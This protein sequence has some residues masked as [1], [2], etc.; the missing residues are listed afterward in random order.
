MS[1]DAMKAFD[2]GQNSGS[3]FRLDLDVM[4][5]NKINAES[6]VRL[7]ITAWHSKLSNEEL[8]IAQVH[9]ILWYGQQ[10]SLPTG[11]PPNGIPSSKTH[12]L[13]LAKSGKLG[14]EYTTY[15]QLTDIDNTTELLLLSN[16]SGRVIGSADEDYY[17]KA[18][19]IRKAM[20][21]FRHY[22]TVALG[23]KLSGPFDHGFLENYTQLINW[24]YKKCNVTKTV[25][26]MADYFE[27]L[28]KA[29]N[30]ESDTDCCS[31]KYR[32]VLS[33]LFQTGTTTAPIKFPD[34]D[35]DNTQL[36]DKEKY[37]PS[38]SILFLYCK[39]RQMDKKTWNS[40]EDEFR[41]EI[42]GTNYN[43]KSWMENKPRLFELID[44][45]AKSNS[46]RGGVN[47]AQ[48]L[49]DED[50]E[51]DRVELEIEPG[52]VMY[53]SPK[54]KKGRGQN[55]KSK[56][57]KYAAAARR[58]QKSNNNASNNRQNSNWNNQSTPAT[59]WNCKICP[60]QNGKFV[61][62]KRGQ[63]CPTNGFIPAR[64]VAV[65]QSNETEQIDQETEIEKEDVKTVQAQVASMR[66][67][68]FPYDS[69]STDESE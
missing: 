22:A 21:H 25:E 52:L 56:V 11:Y 58:G 36:I 57:Q 20:D 26:S 49:E 61:Q 63:K 48:A 17:S 64:M 10:E 38:H 69:S 6:Y 67:A 4:K 23:P 46:S 62:H 45:K 28:D 42:G 30:D 3:M 39:Y 19:T 44:Q 24:V 18:A 33:K 7:W 12:L 55:W 59:Y 35:G 14:G 41:N 40:I 5:A 50:T 27:Q 37:T 68:K 60:S 31:M 8:E 47:R 15:E 65:V 54:T 29:I 34:L 16:I 2:K 32:M 13:T 43:K 51:D 9:Q 1:V 53:V 66:M